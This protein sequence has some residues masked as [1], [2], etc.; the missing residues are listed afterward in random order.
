VNDVSPCPRRGARDVDLVCQ[1]PLDSALRIDWNHDDVTKSAPRGVCTGSTRQ[2][3]RELQVLPGCKSLG[4]P[5]GVEV[6]AAVGARRQEREVESNV[7]WDSR[8]CRATPFGS[9]GPRARDCGRMIVGVD[10]RAAAEVPAG[11][12]RVVRELLEALEAAGTGHRFFLYCREPWDEV[13][14]SHRFCW[15]PIRLPDPGWHVAAAVRAS[16]SCDV[17][18]STNSY[19]TAWMLTV[20][21]AVLVYD[22]VAFLP[23]TRPQA[24]AARIERATIR[25]AVRRAA[26]LV[27]ISHSTEQDL[28]K[29]FPRATGK[30]TVIPL[31][32]GDGFRRRRDS[33]ELEAVA[34]RHGVEV[35]RYVLTTGSLEPRKNLARLI[36]AHGALPTELRRAYPLLVVGPRGWEEEEILSAAKERADGVRLTGFVSDDDLAG[37]YGACAVFCYP[38]LYEGFGLPVLEAMAAGAPVVTS[39]VSSLPEVG[40]EAVVYVEPQNEGSI[41]AALERLLR[42]PEERVALAKRGRLRAAAFS[43][44]RAAQV[45]LNELDLVSQRSQ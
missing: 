23:E 20:P 15:V 26:R 32:A 30:T 33:A 36:R 38:S 8:S 24:R 43:W 4:Q 35:G 37:L 40:G 39:N 41:A 13:R 16:R 11:R 3:Q 29:H 14:L 31:A 2:Q 44:E 12:G 25:P 7:H 42:V 19:L 10:A 27:C 28:L 9:G 1:N 18:L 34:H 17:F 5:A 6:E 45:L 21:C 22:L